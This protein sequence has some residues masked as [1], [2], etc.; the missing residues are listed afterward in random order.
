MLFA[1]IVSYLSGYFRLVRSR[2]FK[3]LVV[4]AKEIEDRLRW[5][6]RYLKFGELVRRVHGLVKDLDVR[7]LL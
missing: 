2:D 7:L 1:C 5:L 6:R 3:D 4:S